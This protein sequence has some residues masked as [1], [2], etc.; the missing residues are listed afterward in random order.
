MTDSPRRPSWAKFTVYAYLLRTTVH[1][2]ARAGLD[3]NANVDAINT[4]MGIPT[5]EPGAISADQVEYLLTVWPHDRVLEATAIEVFALYV[6][7]QLSKSQMISWLNEMPRLDSFTVN[8]RTVDS[9][10]DQLASLS[11]SGLIARLEIGI[12]NRRNLCE[13]PW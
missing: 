8:G 5:G 3:T 13:P 10:E 4:G 9:T 7:G 12:D 2:N 1:T 11:K 6:V